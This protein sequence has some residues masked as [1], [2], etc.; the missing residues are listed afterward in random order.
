MYLWCKCGVKMKAKT[1]KLKELERNRYSILTDDVEH[2]YNCN[3]P[4]N[5]TWHELFEGRN[6]QLSMKYGCCIRLCWKCHQKLQYKDLKYKIKCK[7]KFNEVYPE[8]DFVSI[9]HPKEPELWD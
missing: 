6:R 7:N 2:C 5:L 3:T 8:L 1:K 4:Y 9:F